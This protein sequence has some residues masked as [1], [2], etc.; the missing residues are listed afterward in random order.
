[1]VIIQLGASNYKDF[2]L[3]ILIGNPN[4]VSEV[5]VLPWQVVP[6]TPLIGLFG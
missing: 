5:M 1:M 3:K 6:S 4:L 2:L